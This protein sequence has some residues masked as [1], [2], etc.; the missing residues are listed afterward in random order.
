MARYIANRIVGMV[1]DGV[2]DVI[3]LSAEQ[4]RP[5][6]E[7]GRGVDTEFLTGIGALEKRMLILVDI[8]KLIGSAELTLVGDSLAKAA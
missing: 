7:L 1:V 5:A 3:G 2:S 6:P 4:I 8:E